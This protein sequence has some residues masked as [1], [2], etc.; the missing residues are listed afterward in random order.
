VYVTNRAATK[1]IYLIGPYAK[2]QHYFDR[3]IRKF[4]QKKYRVLYL[5]PDPEILNAARPKQLEVGIQEAYKIISEDIQSQ[6]KDA[7]R[8][9]LGISLGSYLGLNLLHD[10]PIQKFAVVAGGVPLGGVFRT[11]ALFLLQRYKLKKQDSGLDSVE[12]HWVPF[13]QAFKSKDLSGRTILALNSKADR[14]I[15][16]KYLDIFMHELTK[17][18][19][20]VINRRSGYLLHFIQ[21]L[22]ANFRTKRLSAFFTD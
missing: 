18:G 22:S 4:E 20:T 17:A 7:S 15:K 8:Y 12:R 16:G 1:T 10:L 11:S 21:A 9:L 6:P 2:G 19:A 3:L 13:D 14:L 5:Q